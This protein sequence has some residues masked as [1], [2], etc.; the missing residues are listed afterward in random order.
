[1]P[2]SI[3]RKRFERPD[4]EPSG[5]EAGKAPVLAGGIERVRRRA[6][7]EMT[8]DRSLL[9]PGIETAGLHADGDV[10]IEPDLHA[11]AARKI[12]ARLQLPVGDPLHEFDEF[13]LQRVG[14]IA[15]A[16]AFGVVGLAPLL[17]PFP[18][19]LVELVP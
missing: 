1:M 19:G 13:D 11:E 18:P 12:L 8:R 17:R 7:A 3:S 15:Q 16:G 6:N 4:F 5:V 2:A 9:V 14:A 10:E